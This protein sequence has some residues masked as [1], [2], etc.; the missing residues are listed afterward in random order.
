[1]DILYAADPGQWVGNEGCK[2]LDN[3][4]LEVQQAVNGYDKEI[5]GTVRVR[6]EGYDKEALEPLTPGIHDYFLTDPNASL[7]AG[8]EPTLFEGCSEGWHDDHSAVP[9]DF[10]AL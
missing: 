6:V 7:Y 3:L 4:A 9:F 5:S 8:M 2:A 1:L 10:L